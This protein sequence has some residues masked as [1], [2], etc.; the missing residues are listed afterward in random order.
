MVTIMKTIRKYS[1]NLEEGPQ[2][3]NLKE[4]YKIVRSEYFTHSN[5]V[6]FWVELP[7]KADIPDIK[8]E[9]LV[10][11]TNEVIPM[12]YIYVGTALNKSK[13]ESYHV[14]EVPTMYIANNKRFDDIHSIDNFAA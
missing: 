13:S 2:T 9:F 10:K 4:G 8:K 6:S 11:K 7:L 14:F 3:I 5:S 1:L 12:S